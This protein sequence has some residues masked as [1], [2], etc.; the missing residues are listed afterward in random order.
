MVIEE[1]DKNEIADEAARE[2]IIDIVRNGMTDTEEKEIS[3]G[4]HG[5]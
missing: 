2:G 1:M 3:E 4:K 5:D